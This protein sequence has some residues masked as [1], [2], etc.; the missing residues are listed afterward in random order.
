MG[1]YGAAS[2]TISMNHSAD[3]PSPPHDAA[4]GGGPCLADNR[5]DPV[6]DAGQILRVLSLISSASLAAVVLSAATNKIIAVAAG[7][8]GIA[9]MGLYR[10]LGACVAGTLALGYD[11]I[12]VQRI[13]T[14]RAKESASGEA[15]A[16]ALLLAVQT[17]FIFIMATAFAGALARW[18]FGSFGFETHLWEVRVVLV[19]GLANLVL[20]TVTAFVKG[21]GLVAAVARIQIAMAAA[22]LLL[23]IP[24]LQFGR[25][26][27]A[28]NVG[29]GGLI[30][31]LVGL[32]YLWRLRGWASLEFS[33]ARGWKVLRET[34]GS[35][36]LLSLESLV[37][38]GT[39]AHIQAIVGRSHGLT[40]LGN[41]NAAMLMINTLVTVLMSAAR[42]YVLPTAG[43]IQD[44]YLKAILF[45]RVMRLSLIAQTLAGLGL[46]FL[47]PVV[48]RVLFT[49]EFSS[50][51]QLLAIL[52]LSFIGQVFGWN[53][54][55]FMLH[56]GDFG[57]SCL[58]NAT[59]CALFISGTLLCISKGWPLTSIAWAYA[60]SHCLYGANYAAFSVRRYGKEVLPGGLVRLTILCLGLL[61]SGYAV[62]RL[63]SSTASLTF[64]VAA[65]AALGLAAA[66]SDLL[67]AS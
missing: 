7:T 49:T 61:L 44:R 21:H 3:R 64:L 63:G 16:A 58:L 28:F 53:Y 10:N 14:A 66:Q 31:T 35:S 30:G 33:P 41:Y 51:P 42:T 23:I 45:S 19:M 8:A 18:M 32:Y 46:I 56:K 2:S 60:I 1:F 62:S 20:Q 9:L 67:E 12:F 17:V 4:P 6:L 27:L 65:L 15:N 29:S 40:A 13:S 57:L 5:F 43:H 26:G 54:S 52:S 59:W 50:A 22:S 34:A 39:F 25:L 24:L 38:L 47:A 48:I 37:L 36:I 11:L 55:T